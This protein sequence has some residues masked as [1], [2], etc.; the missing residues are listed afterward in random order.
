MA[1]ANSQKIAENAAGP[2]SVTSDGTSVSKYSID[3]QIKADKY[4]RSA[5]SLKGNPYNKMVRVRTIAR[6]TTD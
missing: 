2:K 5:E 3:E 6:G 4:R 1:E